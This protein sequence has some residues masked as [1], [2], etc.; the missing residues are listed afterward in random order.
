MTLSLPGTLA[1]HKAGIPVLEAP[2]F[3]RKRYRRI[4]PRFPAAVSGRVVQ[5]VRDISVDA[6]DA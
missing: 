5:W 6:R 2:A 1:G 3:I 4:L